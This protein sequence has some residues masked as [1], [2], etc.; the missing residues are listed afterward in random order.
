[1]ETSSRL[2]KYVTARSLWAAVSAF[3]ASL[4]RVSL[5]PSSVQRNR[6]LWLVFRL[7]KFSNLVL[8]VRHQSIGKW[9]TSSSVSLNQC[10]LPFEMVVR[11]L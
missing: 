2:V 8:N 5:F 7:Q 10:Q 1:M 6:S 3:P 11:E 9:E 4:L